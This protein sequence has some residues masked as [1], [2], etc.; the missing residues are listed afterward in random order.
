MWEEAYTKALEVRA[1]QRQLAKDW[2]AKETY[3]VDEA[4]QHFSTERQQARARRRKTLG[5][6]SPRGG[7]GAST[8]ETSRGPA[9]V[10]SIHKNQEKEA[11][12]MRMG[13]VTEA[14]KQTV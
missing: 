6:E 2:L 14:Q 7:A 3:A 8:W 10:K 1:T 12:E 11:F 9:I 5:L 13:S 4:L